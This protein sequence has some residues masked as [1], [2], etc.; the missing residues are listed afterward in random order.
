MLARHCYNLL[1][2]A[3]SGLGDDF[4]AYPVT[5]R[6]L[7]MPFPTPHLLEVPHCYALLMRLNKRLILL[8]VC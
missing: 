2:R 1:L 5:C 7:A 8:V 6:Q 4:G 3:V